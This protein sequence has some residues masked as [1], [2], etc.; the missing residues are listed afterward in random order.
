[1]KIGLFLILSY[2]NFGQA[3]ENYLQISEITGQTIEN[4]P[5]QLGRPFQAGEISDFPQA[6]IDGN[7]VLI[8]ADVKTRWSVGSVKHAIIC[9][10]N[11]NIQANSSIKVSFVNQST[12]NNSN[13]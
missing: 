13:F 4:Y 7:P 2:L 11:P 6:V 5:I 3:I 9:F 1:M 12:G 10:H 8:Q